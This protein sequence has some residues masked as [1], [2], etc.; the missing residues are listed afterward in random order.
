MLKNWFKKLRI[1]NLP[2]VDS[3]FIYHLIYVRVNT[4]YSRFQLGEVQKLPL[5]VPPCQGGMKAVV[6]HERGN[7]CNSFKRE[8]PNLEKSDLRLTL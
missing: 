1:S 3:R 2:D 6:P 5:S 4:K 8:H 7:C